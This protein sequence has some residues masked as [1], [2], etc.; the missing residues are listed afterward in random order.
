MRSFFDIKCLK[1]A[2][3][4]SFI[5]ISLYSLKIFNHPFNTVLNSVFFINL[6][7]S[8]VFFLLLYYF[9]LIYFIKKNDFFS[10]V[11]KYSVLLYLYIVF[12]KSIIFL[13]GNS[14]FA[15]FFSAFGFIF[16]YYKIGKIFLLVLILL[17]FILLLF[18]FKNFEKFINFLSIYGLVILIFNIYF[19]FNSNQI[20][21][22]KISESFS[23]KDI[24]K[25]YP[26]KRVILLIFDEFDMKTFLK[27]EN[28]IVDKNGGF[29]KI[30]NN[31]VFF[32]DTYAPGRDTFNSMPSILIGHDASGK[33]FWNRKNFGFITKKSKVEM[34]NYE[35]SLFNFSKTRKTA[36]LHSTLVSYCHYITGITTCH[37]KTNEIENKD[38]SIYFQGLDSITSFFTNFKFNLL[39]NEKEKTDK[40]KIQKI[41]RDHNYE[42][43]IKNTKNIIKN[44]LQIIKNND[45]DII[46]VHYP[47]PHYPSFFSKEKYGINKSTTLEEDYILNFQ[48]VDDLLNEINK[49]INNSPNDQINLLIIS[50]DHGNRLYEEYYGEP[51]PVPTI[52]KLYNDDFSSKID[53]PIS[54]RYIKD[55]ISMFFSSNLKVQH[56]K[57][58]LISKPVKKHVM[59]NYNIL[60][61]LMEN[62]KYHLGLD[63]N[64]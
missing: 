55:I 21:S 42:I 48:L 39:E 8:I 61:K 51:R 41:Q 62:P 52:F 36:L 9:Y 7:I 30:I 2:F 28:T 50:S 13:T 16:A 49:E 5:N 6:L 17:S 12:L 27:N 15:E 4:L 11:I 60:K 54:N 19:I 25:T 34:V 32:T 45:H 57:D 22:Q 3:C 56:I 47:L 37:D 40:S 43:N 29:K 64:K 18:F 23:V 63:F 35:N 46:L 14:S 31:S 58:Y 26:K 20:I 24:S 38:L 33:I 1:Y 44:S 53:Q 10:L 59:H